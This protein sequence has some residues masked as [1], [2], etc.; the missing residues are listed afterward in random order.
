MKKIISPSRVWKA[1]KG[2]TVLLA[3]LVATFFLSY[4]F[5][6]WPAGKLFV[7]IFFSFLLISGAFIVFKK[8][9]LGLIVTGLVLISLILHWVNFYQAAEGLGPWIAFFNFLFCCLLAFIVLIL[10]FH[11]GPVTAHRITGAIV[12]YLLFGLMWGFLY[13][14]IALLLPEAFK[15][16][17]AM[18]TYTADMSQNSLLYFSFE[19]LTTLGYGDILAVHPVARVLVILEALTGQLF[20]AILL[21]RLVSLQI[22]HSRDK[23]RDQ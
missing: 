4:P 7:L 3:F 8:R 2:L 21:A 10:V 17:Q 14:L 5:V 6:L 1:E 11:E 16:P 23:K 18:T 15:L 19:T 13:Q 9:I 12:V 22:V 20:P